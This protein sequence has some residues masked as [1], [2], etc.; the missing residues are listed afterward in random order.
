MFASEFYL[1][2]ISWPHINTQIQ[3]MESPHENAAQIHPDD[4]IWC[5]W[6][7]LQ[8][9]IIVMSQHAACIMV[10]DVWKRKVTA[11]DQALCRET[12]KLF[13]LWLR[14]TNTPWSTHYPT[15]MYFLH[16]AVKDLTNAMCHPRKNKP[17][18]FHLPPGIDLER[19]NENKWWGVV[20]MELSEASEGPV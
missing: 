19:H 8:W 11:E 17:A 13:T 20:H 18:K 3:I 2:L 9:K 7:R 14:S 12:A 6:H 5:G 10:N 1:N 16:S 4:K 15:R